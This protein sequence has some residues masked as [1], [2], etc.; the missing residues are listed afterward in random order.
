ML[1][2]AP[3]TKQNVT[4]CTPPNDRHYIDVIGAV[5]FGKRFNYGYSASITTSGIFTQTARDDHKAYSDAVKAL[6]A[7][8]KDALIK[9]GHITPRHSDRVIDHDDKSCP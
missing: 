1:K 5:T 6:N 7:G 9:S 8:D 3:S 4:D 2:D